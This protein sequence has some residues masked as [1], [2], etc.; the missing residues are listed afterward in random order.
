MALFDAS[1]EHT[2]Y[3]DPAW[4]AE[5]HPLDDAATRAALATF[6]ITVTPAPDLPLVTLQDSGLG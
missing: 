5:R 3:D 4:V 2:P 1:G 6:G